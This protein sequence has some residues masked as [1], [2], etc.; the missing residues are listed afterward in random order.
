M[1]AANQQVCWRVRVPVL[2]SRAHVN[3]LV[4]PTSYLGEI[5]MAPA[6][7]IFPIILI[8]VHIN[9]GLKNRTS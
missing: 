5:F 2:M 1:W 9:F 7:S 3:A 4:K 8:S 6:P